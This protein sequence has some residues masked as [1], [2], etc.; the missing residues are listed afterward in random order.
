MCDANA[1]AQ[2]PHPV[3]I[4]HSGRDLLED[5]LRPRV[6]SG[7]KL[8]ELRQ[9][10][11]ASA[12][13]NVREV[14]AIVDAEV[15][16]GA[17]ESLVEGLPES[18]VR[19]H[20]PVEPLEHVLPVGP[21]GSRREPKEHD[22]LQGLE[23]RVVGGGGG[24]MEFVDDHHFVGVRCEAG[25]ALGVQGLDRSENVPSGLGSCPADEEFAETAVTEDHLKHRAALL[26]NLLTVSNE[27]KTH[28][29]P[30]AAQ[31]LVVESCDP[32]LAGAGGGDH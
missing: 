21:L 17:K 12:P 4:H 29:A 27:E 16:E 22:R 23:E 2:C 5:A 10:V 9:V 1:E 11:S 8:L 20:A 26:Q 3:R 31:A 24:V 7:V 30:L 18:Q 15:V 32:G 19:G 14:G 6:L 13:P 28:L 25:E